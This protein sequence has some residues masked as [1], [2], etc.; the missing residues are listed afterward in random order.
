VFDPAAPRVAEDEAQSLAHS[1]NI[2][3]RQRLTDCSTCHR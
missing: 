1:L 3:S 2:E